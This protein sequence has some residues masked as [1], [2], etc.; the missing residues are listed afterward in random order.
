M[1]ANERLGR[2]IA[3]VRIALTTIVAAACTDR[4]RGDGDA[5]EE[6]YPRQAQP[7]I[8]AHRIGSVKSA[9]SPFSRR[10]SPKKPT[11]PSAL[12]RTRLT[13][14]ASFSR[15]WKPSTLPSSIPGKVSLSGARTASLV[16]PRFCQPPCPIMRASI[17]NA[18]PPHG[19]DVIP[20]GNPPSRLGR[21]CEHIPAGGRA[22]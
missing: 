2:V 5:A 10:F 21:S 9:N 1:T 8:D 6:H 17:I 22:E 19:M 13:M 14:T 16:R 18:P 11:S 3:T 15:P 12:L 7:F 4:T 20:Q